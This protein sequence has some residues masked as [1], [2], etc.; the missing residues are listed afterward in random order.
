[1]NLSVNGGGGPAVGGDAGL[2][3]IGN[4]ASAGDA[5][6]RTGTNNLSLVPGTGAQA[7]GFG[8]VVWDPADDEAFPTAAT[9]NGP[10]ISV[11][12][13]SGP[14]TPPGTIMCDNP[15]G[16]RTAAD[17]AGAGRGA[18]PAPLRFRRTALSS[19]ARAASAGQGASLESRPELSVRS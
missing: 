2:I 12:P 13:A 1:A 3:A 15:Y 5:I 11:T 17:N 19:P 4:E 8:V 6:T 7:G 10:A 14:A 9:A 16:V 18:R